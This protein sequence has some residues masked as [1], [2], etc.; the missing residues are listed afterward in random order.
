MK[1]D[2]CLSCVFVFLKSWQ[3]R[4]I[5]LSKTFL[6]VKNL[7]S[8]VEPAVQLM[9]KCYPRVPVPVTSDKSAYSFPLPG[10]PVDGWDADLGPYGT[11]YISWVFKPVSLLLCQTPNSCYYSP[12]TYFPLGTQRMSHSR[13]LAFTHCLWLFVLDKV[14]IALAKFAIVIT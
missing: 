14:V 13:D 9:R 1:K 10:R 6:T 8:L 3:I 2:F 7:E 5:F 4:N 11:V 12:L